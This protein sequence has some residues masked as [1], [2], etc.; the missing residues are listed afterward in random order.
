MSGGVLKHAWRCAG[1]AM[2][3]VSASPACARCVATSDSVRLRVSDCACAC[4][5]L[6][7][8][9]PRRGSATSPRL[10][11]Q[12]VVRSPAPP[13]LLTRPAS[14]AACTQKKNTDS[15]T[16]HSVHS[17][18]HT[19]HTASARQGQGTWSRAS[20]SSDP[21]DLWPRRYSQAIH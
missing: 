1:C 19:P 9:F 2:C 14:P 11:V 5:C 4:A 18:E 7:V 10:H 16:Y 20:F 13:R 15:Q 12:S 17:T 21:Y 6:L 8:S 3:G